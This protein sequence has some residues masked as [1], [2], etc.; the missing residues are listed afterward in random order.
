MYQSDCRDLVASVMKKRFGN[1]VSVTGQNVP[2]PSVKVVSPERGSRT[3]EESLELQPTTEGIL[4]NLS[5]LARCRALFSLDFDV[6]K[7]ALSV[8]EV[9][10]LG[11]NNPSQSWA[12]RPLW[13]WTWEERLFTE[14]I[15]IVNDLIGAL[16]MNVRVTLSNL[17]DCGVQTTF[18]WKEDSRTRASLRLLYNQPLPRP[19]LLDSD[20]EHSHCID[21]G[22]SRIYLGSKN[23]QILDKE[24]IPGN[25]GNNVDVLPANEDKLTPLFKESHDE[26]LM[27]LE[28]SQFIDKCAARTASASAYIPSEIEANSCN[29]RRDFYIDSDGIDMAV[30]SQLPPNLRS[31]VRL[32][33]AMQAREKKRQTQQPG[34]LWNWLLETKGSTTRRHNGLDRSL[35][36]TIFERK[37]KSVRTIRQYLCK[38]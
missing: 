24:R 12:Q 34:K 14:A 7:H 25:T 11:H 31:E 1:F 5:L 6:G 17:D 26:S 32:A 10:P 8:N 16:P 3:I 15:I 19:K 38:K 27:K 9:V 28:E 29:G 36:S 18:P 22:A 37:R 35:R 21:G 13:S 4:L 30:L 33:M 23:S 2:M 20:D